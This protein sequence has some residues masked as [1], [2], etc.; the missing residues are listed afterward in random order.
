MQVNLLVYEYV[1][2]VAYCRSREKK[3]L[4]LHASTERQITY[5][6]GI[7]INREWPLTTKCKTQREPVSQSVKHRH[8]TPI[9]KTKQLSGSNTVATTST[10]SLVDTWR[11]NL[12]A[13]KLVRTSWSE[14]VSGGEEHRG[15]S[16]IAQDLTAP[17]TLWPNDE[18]EGRLREEK[19]LWAACGGGGGVGWNGRRLE[20]EEGG[21]RE[22]RWKMKGWWTK[23]ELRVNEV[24]VGFGEIYE[25]KEEEANDIESDK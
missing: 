10:K 5:I 18:K 25:W 9:I 19:C 6:P 4:T 7:Y 16:S 22:R 13:N 14:L 11:G 2:V 17:S 23:D 1:C 24:V 15:R 3:I 8:I 12:T 21:I 20:E